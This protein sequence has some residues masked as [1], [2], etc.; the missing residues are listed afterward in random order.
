M[1]IRTTKFGLNVFSSFRLSDMS[2]AEYFEQS[3]RLCER[4]DRL[5][6]HSA[7]AVEHYFHDYGGHSPN[8]LIFL[9]AVAEAG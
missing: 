1:E 5:G 2:T 9:S 6:Y 4:A 7:T 8:P 3:L